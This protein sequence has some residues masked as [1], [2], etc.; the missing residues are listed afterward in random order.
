MGARMVSRF[1]VT[2]THSSKRFTRRAIKN[3]IKSFL[4]F[5]GKA[6]VTVEDL[7]TQNKPNELENG[8]KP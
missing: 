6:R 2:V 4:E 8:T 1:I 7:K 3:E 5:D